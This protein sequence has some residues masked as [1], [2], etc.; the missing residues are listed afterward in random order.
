MSCSHPI[1]GVVWPN[2]DTPGHPPGTCPYPSYPPTPTPWARARQRR[3]VMLFCTDIVN[4]YR[5]TVPHILQYPIYHDWTNALSLS[6]LDIVVRVRQFIRLSR[7]RP[8]Y[9]LWNSCHTLQVCRKIDCVQ[10]RALS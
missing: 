6:S 10:G 5:G 1:G 7:T 4:K 2:Q 9:P 8:Y 3:V